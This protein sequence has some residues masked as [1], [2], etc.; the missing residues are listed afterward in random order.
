MPSL[1]K[2]IRLSC[3]LKGTLKKQMLGNIF[4]QLWQRFNFKTSTMTLRSF[5]SITIRWIR[6]F[7]KTSVKTSSSP[8]FDALSR[9][10]IYFLVSLLWKAQLSKHCIWYPWI[11]W[12][13]LM[14]VMT[15][16]V[17]LSRI[18][19]T[20][21]HLCS[22]RTNWAIWLW[23]NCRDKCKLTIQKGIFGFSFYFSSFT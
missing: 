14:Q 7:T 22:S 15:R 17:Y 19:N 1:F 13:H 20:F 9:W 6:F 3:S 16:V 2:L 4:T 8:K 11:Y 21:L 10:K 12:T 5:L 23:T 18:T